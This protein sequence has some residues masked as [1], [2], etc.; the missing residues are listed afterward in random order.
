M[1]QRTEM[2]NKADQEITALVHFSSLAPTRREGRRMFWLDVVPKLRSI[3]TV[4]L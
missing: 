4:T 3:Q 2:V 1:C